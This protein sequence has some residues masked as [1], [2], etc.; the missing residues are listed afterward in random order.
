MVI[1]GHVLNL[2]PKGF[3]REQSLPIAHGSGR[4]LKVGE[5]NH[6]PRTLLSGTNSKYF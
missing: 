5:G 2:D 4:V 1:T 3:L 6:G